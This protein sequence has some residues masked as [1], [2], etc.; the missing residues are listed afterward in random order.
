MSNEKIPPPA[1]SP[2][3]LD[4]VRGKLRLKHYSIRTEEGYVHWITR[5]IVFHD[6]KHPLEM[7]GPEIE[8]FL[9]DLAVNGRVAA[10]T[11][12]QAFAAILFLYREVLEIELPPLNAVRAQRPERLP[13]VLSVDEVRQIFDRIDGEHLLICQLMYGCGLRILE[14]CR[15][16]VHDVDFE[17]HQIMVRDGKGEK[18]RA[19][20]LPR[21]L[22]GRLQEQIANVKR[23]H[24]K[25]G[26]AHV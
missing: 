26:R 1:N 18:D 17:R 19:V 12:N 5:F 22:V 11:Q 10:S 25:I 13:V 8:A 21:K 9:T 7:G 20:P 4:R 23:L 3:L 24:E 14:V 15:L 16:R 6:K 2:K